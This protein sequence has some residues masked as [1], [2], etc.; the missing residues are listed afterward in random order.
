MHQAYL[1]SHL[2]SVVGSV[3]DELKIGE[4]ADVETCLQVLNIEKGLELGTKTLE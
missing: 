3:T 2:S 4:A 1:P